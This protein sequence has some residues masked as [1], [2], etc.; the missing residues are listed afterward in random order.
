[1]SVHSVCICVV[2]AVDTCPPFI[3]P[4]CAQ[5]EGF[6]VC[7]IGYLLILDPFFLF[8]IGY[9]IYI[10]LYSL[11]SFSIITFTSANLKMNINFSLST[12]Q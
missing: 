2:N 4:F 10:V 7:H 8:G 1:M 5:M 3:K 6:F 12:L 9:L 11:Y